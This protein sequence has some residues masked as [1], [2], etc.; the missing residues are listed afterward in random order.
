MRSC[1][2]VMTREPDSPGH[3][4]QGVPRRSLFFDSEMRVHRVPPAFLGRCVSDIN[5]ECMELVGPRSL[6]YLELEHALTR[7]RRVD[8]EDGGFS[9]RGFLDT[10]SV[11]TSSVEMRD[12]DIFRA[13]I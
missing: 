13:R 10:S 6:R 8:E 3:R 5:Y 1:T 7:T 9:S 11:E 4:M 12:G 2:S